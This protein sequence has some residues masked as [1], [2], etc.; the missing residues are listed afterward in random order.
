M[1]RADGK[2]LAASMPGG[3]VPRLELGVL[4]PQEYAGIG[5]V[6][7]DDY[8]DEVGHNYVHDAAELHADPAYAN[9][10][11][12][13]HDPNKSRWLQ[14]CRPGI[15]SGV[16]QR[17]SRARPSEPLDRGHDADRGEARGR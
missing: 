7:K 6:L 4:G 1:C 11:H 9:Y 15:P 17:V 10:G 2:I 8:L 3:G 13:A 14:Y 5:P 12:V 16:I